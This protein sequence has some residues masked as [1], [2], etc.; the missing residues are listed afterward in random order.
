[1]TYNF[2]WLLN[3]SVYFLILSRS[4]T[5]R[6]SL[7]LNL[8]FFPVSVKNQKISAP[9]TSSHVSLDRASHMDQPRINRKHFMHDTTSQG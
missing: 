4:Q 3:S 1:M 2:V 8:P 5:I 7:Y 9:I 6:E